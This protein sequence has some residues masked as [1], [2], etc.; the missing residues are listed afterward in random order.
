MNTFP[1]HDWIVAAIFVLCIGVTI[2]GALIAAFTKRIIRSVSGL[3]VCCLGLA[4]L[5]Y[6]LNS[7][8]LA[9]MEILIYIGAVC[10]TII[11]GV[12]LAEPDEPTPENQKRPFPVISP[13][14]SLGIGAA[15]FV[16][17]A[18]LSISTCWKAPEA[19]TNDGSIE[20]IGKA[21]LT[22]YSVPFELI[23]LVLL[24]AILGALVI[25]RTGRTK[26]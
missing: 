1:F 9:L 14:I 24:V 8:F 22:T 17:I 10:V 2:T 19:V 6:F 20:S 7:P 3:A 4:G 23:S 26:E 18:W 12:M 21:L 13:A 11:F 25:A 15:V 5:F 16:G